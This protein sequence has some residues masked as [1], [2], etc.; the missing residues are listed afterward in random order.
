MK[1]NESAVRARAIEPSYPS[2]VSYGAGERGESFPRERDTLII[3]RK[4]R[5]L[6]IPRLKASNDGILCK[7][8]SNERVE[9][10]HRRG[11]FNNS[12]EAKMQTG[13]QLRAGFLTAV[14]L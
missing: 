5:V 6:M 9:L 12:H 2:R 3:Q 4:L 1:I 11:T 13:Y 8:D 10:I 14:T 7:R